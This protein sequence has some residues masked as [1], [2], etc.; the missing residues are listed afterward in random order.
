LD[1]ALDKLDTLLDLEPEQTTAILLEA[2]ILAD[3]NTAK[4]YARLQQ[5]LQNNPDDNLLR[6]QY[7]RLLTTTDMP[8]A[9]EQFEI[10]SEQHPDDGD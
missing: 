6:L 7:A 1:S 8:A 9:R 3:Q 2:K 5:M 4:P 10:L